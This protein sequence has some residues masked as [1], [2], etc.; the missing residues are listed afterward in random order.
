MRYAQILS[1]QLTRLGYQ[2]VAVPRDATPTGDLTVT[3]S[4]AE[5]NGGNT[6]KRI[7]IGFGAGRSEFDV[8]GRVTRADGSVVGEF[9]ES[10]AGGGWGEQAALEGAMRRT[11]I[12]IGRMIYT[13]DYR[14][15]APEERPGAKA[16]NASHAPSVAASTT[17][18]Q[19]LQ[20]LD[21]L[22]A[23]GAITS[24]EYEAKRRAILE[25]F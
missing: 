24:S 3:G 5:I 23:E 22:R 8:Y 1:E 25:S 13:G 10:R 2:A 15:N 19:R 6:A 4:V 11:A 14:R 18:E 20:T 17:V 21:R 16:F 7:L 12:L 9:T